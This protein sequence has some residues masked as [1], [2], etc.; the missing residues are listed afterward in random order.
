M[1]LARTEARVDLEPIQLRPKPVPLPDGR[2][3]KRNAGAAKG[4]AIQE[5]LGGPETG[6][7]E[8]L[9]PDGDRSRPE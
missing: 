5:G 8:A 2:Q 9:D 4:P 7:F 3:N 1:Q 6:L